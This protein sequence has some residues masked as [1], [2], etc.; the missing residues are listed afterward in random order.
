MF[1]W[2]SNV[3][4][5]SDRYEEAAAAQKK[6][7][8][9]MG[10]SAEEV[11]GLSDAYATSGKDG[12]WQWQLDYWTEEAKQEYVSP[13]LELLSK[14]VYGPSSGGDL[15]LPDSVDEFHVFNDF[16]QAPIAL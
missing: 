3:Y 16:T 11:A 14:V 13:S 10:A 12:Y 15:I 5:V 1:G 8:T 4:E 7:L 2:L 9:L 6:F